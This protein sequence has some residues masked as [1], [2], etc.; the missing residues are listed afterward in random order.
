M[1]K[2]T[3]HPA[4]YLPSV[5]VAFRF[6]VVSL[7]IHNFNLLMQLPAQVLG[8]KH[9]R[10]A[11][12]DAPHAPKELTPTSDLRNT[13][14]WLKESPLVCSGVIRSDRYLS[15]SDCL[16]TIS[17]SHSSFAFASIKLYEHK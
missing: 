16:S 12:S 5:M 2:Q 15:F 8:A 10:R 11:V 9:N 14:S 7:F 6:D 3:A 1:S 13:W 4:S 17:C